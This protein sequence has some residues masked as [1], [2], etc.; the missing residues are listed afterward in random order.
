MN[1]KT[2]RAKIDKFLIKITDGRC[3]LLTEKTNSAFRV[4]L[5]L[6]KCKF[7][8][9]R[10]LRRIRNSEQKQT[11]S[12]PRDLPKN[13]FCKLGNDVLSTSNR[14][15]PFQVLG[16]SPL[17]RTHFSESDSCLYELLRRPNDH[18]NVKF[19]CPENAEIASIHAFVFS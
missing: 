10:S 7:L 2:C 18:Q 17:E 5:F 4:A 16:V 14:Y 15:R 9:W 13:I 8:F 19:V 1:P 12:A 3:F 11:A 6:S